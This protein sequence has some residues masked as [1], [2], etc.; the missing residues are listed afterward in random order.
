MDGCMDGWM[1]VVTLT[2]PGP[3]FM[4]NDLRVFRI[5]GMTHT[6]SHGTLVSS[7]WYETRLSLPS[8]PPR[9]IITC[10]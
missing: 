8:S 3:C 4:P 7:V 1:D 10:C 2:G 6:G 5:V 9:E